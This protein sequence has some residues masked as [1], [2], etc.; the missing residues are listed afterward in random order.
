MI[1]S[2]AASWEKN[3]KNI[4]ISFFLL[5][6]L[7]MMR[8]IVIISAF[9]FSDYPPFRIMMALDIV[10][11]VLIPFLIVFISADMM[12]TTTSFF[13]PLINI[14]IVFPICDVFFLDLA[15]LLTPEYFIPFLIGGFGFGLIG[16]AGNK[17]HGDFK[18][19]MIF[20]TIGM[21]IIVM[22]FVNFIPI[23]YYVLTGD[24][25]I[26]QLIPGL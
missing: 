13:L 10:F 9:L 5:V 11:V 7:L 25:M 16:L 23:T 20:F 18:K 21:M 15:L 14:G 8:F 1:E 24:A 6:S 2:I 17:Y 3:R 22:N 19:S 12:K 26:L 4:G